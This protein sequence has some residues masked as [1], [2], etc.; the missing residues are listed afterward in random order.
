MR[1]FSSDETSDDEE[2]DEYEADVS[3]DV[4]TPM[5]SC[6]N[7]RP[8]DNNNMEMFNL[9]FGQDQDMSGVEGYILNFHFL[10][11]RFPLSFVEMSSEAGCICKFW[12]T[13]ITFTE[14]T[15]GLLSIGD[16]RI[17]VF[18]VLS[19]TFLPQKIVFIIL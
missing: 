13:I 15:D 7:H 19:C 4:T 1:F 2:D 8:F 11:K 6:Y 16:S 5:T 17:S 10:E 9:S 3:D 14:Q 12:L 18:V